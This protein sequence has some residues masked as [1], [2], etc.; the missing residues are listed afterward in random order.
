[1]R[2]FYTIDTGHNEVSCGG[3][4]WENEERQIGGGLE[5]EDRWKEDGWKFVNNNSHKEGSKQQLIALVGETSHEQRY[6]F[7]KRD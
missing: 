5:E 2:Q 4:K 1:M 3:H 6:L 7:R